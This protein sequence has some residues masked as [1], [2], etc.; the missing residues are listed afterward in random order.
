[1]TKRVHWL[2]AVGRN[3]RTLFYYVTSTPQAIVHIH[4]HSEMC[5][6][7]GM[8]T[9]YRQTVGRN[10]RTLFYFVMCTYATDSWRELCCV[11]TLSLS[12]VI[13]HINSHRETCVVYDMYTGYRQLEGTSELYSTVLCVY[14]VFIYC[15]TYY[16]AHHTM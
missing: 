4:S 13:V 5:F 10:E 12:S 15:H 7:Y 14:A 3:E 6:V 8:Y 1:M 16:L 9:G 11:C 2:Q